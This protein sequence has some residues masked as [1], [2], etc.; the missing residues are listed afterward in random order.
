MV[1]APVR[2][3]H[4]NAQHP[5]I[6]HLQWPL[7]GDSTKHQEKAAIETARQKASATC[8]VTMVHKAPGASRPNCNEPAQQKL[9]TSMGAPPTNPGT[10]LLKQGVSGSEGNGSWHKASDRFWEM[11]VHHVVVGTT[12]DRAGNRQPRFKSQ[13]LASQA[14]PPPTPTPAPPAKK[15]PSRLC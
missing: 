5:S 3:R 14:R 7:K 11:T 15:G 10:A 9:H 1:V 2:V 6:A 4:R 8:L 13:D 12:G